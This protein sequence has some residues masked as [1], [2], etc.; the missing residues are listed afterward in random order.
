L[1]E[2]AF[3]SPQDFIGRIKGHYTNQV[4]AQFY[5]L[6]GSFDFLGSPVSLVSNIGT[7][8]H[9][10]F[11]EPA[12]AI[13]TSPAEFGKGV[14]KGTTSLVKNS[15]VGIFNSTSKFA[16]SVSR[17][18]AALSFDTEYIKERER[19]SREK[20]KGAVQGVASG[21]KG[22]G[23]GLFQG[24]TGIIAQPLK[25][26][27]KEGVVGFAKGI[28]KGVAGAAAKPIAGTFD[29]VSQTS[30][31]I[32]NATLAKGKEG[33][34]RARPPRYFGKN[35]RLKRYDRVKAE[36]TTLVNTIE[37]GK[38]K[39]EKYVYHM[40][41]KAPPKPN[42]LLETK[43]KNETSVLVL[44]DTMIALVD[45]SEVNEPLWVVSIGNVKHL[46]VKGTNLVFHLKNTSKS[47]LLENV[48]GGVLKREADCLSKEDALAF[49]GKF[50]K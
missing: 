6:L 27:Q 20:P 50:K 39:K 14:A 44:T 30:E 23:K 1:L 10:F 16:G 11:Y 49:V 26:G 3:L 40:L 47:G 21:M 29:L 19:A 8:V 43:N 22:F 37:N 12:Q 34:G 4:I 36:G 18:A 42:I 31:G 46:D 32:R 48:T 35:G 25:G 24:A 28:G 41:V 15:V 2:N 33:I 45:K 13:V 38:H 9:D 5:T 17:G 7:G